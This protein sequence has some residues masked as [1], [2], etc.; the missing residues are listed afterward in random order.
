MNPR[1]LGILLIGY[2][3]GVVAWDIQKSVVAKTFEMFL[4]PGEQGIFL[5]TVS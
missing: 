1:D 5:S 3:G 2:E 4:P